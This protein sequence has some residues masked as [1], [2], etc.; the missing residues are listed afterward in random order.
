MAFDERQLQDMRERLPEYLEAA[1]GIDT[2]RAFRCLHP[3]HDDKHPSMRY[4]GKRS[5][6]KC[7]SCGES[8]DVFDVAGW[9]ART[10]DFK[11]QVRHAAEV[12]GASVDDGK[13]LPYR[14]KHRHDG[15]RWGKTQPVEGKDVLA[16][17]QDAAFALFDDPAAKSALHHFR[18]R[19]FTDEEIM[20][21]GWGWVPH[22]SAMFDQ[23]FDKAPRVAQGYLCMPFP[24]DEE[25]SAVRYCV[26]RECRN[27]AMAKEWCARGKPSPIWREHLLS[28]PGTVYVTEGVFD[29]AAVTAMTGCT[30]CALCG[31]SGVGRLLGIVERTPTASRPLLALALDAD[32]Q[33]ARLRDEIAEGMESLGADYRVMPDYPGG[34]KDA[35]DMLRAERRENEKARQR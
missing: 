34:A 19:G 6:V 1:H 28:Q 23:G 14:P 33:G 30:A 3:D 18:W 16:A 9:D 31:S 35:C 29:A 2:R 27:D 5:R 11:E 17:V 24:E 7:F 22:P 25:W 32:R 15:P 20:R 21:N 4:D 8:G 12:L 26:F 13:P 10:D